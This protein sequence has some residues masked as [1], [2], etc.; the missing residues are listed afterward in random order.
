L[1]INYE[2]AYLIRWALFFDSSQKPVHIP[3][4]KI[5]AGYA[6]N[7]EA[8]FFSAKKGFY[9]FVNNNKNS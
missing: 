8:I 9:I 1:Q 5:F 7:Y 4:V 3:D 2:R 6:I